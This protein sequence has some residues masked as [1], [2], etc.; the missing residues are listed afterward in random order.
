[1]S[2]LS[3]DR[4]AHSKSEPKL[5][6]IIGYPSSGTTLLRDILDVH[7]DLRIAGEMP[8]LLSLVSVSDLT[9]TR[10]N[11]A[12][13]KDKVLLTDVYEHFRNTK[14][15]YEDLEQRFEKRDGF[16]VRHVYAGLL[17]A[18]YYAYYGNKT[19]QYTESLD[20]LWSLFPMTKVI[21]VVR[22]IRDVVLSF[23][24]KWNKSCLLAA[25]KWTQRM[26]SGV[27]SMES[28]PKDMCLIVR[29]EDLLD[30]PQQQVE[31]ICRFLEV[32]VSDRMLNHTRFRRVHFAG[33]K[34]IN[35]EIDPS[36][37]GK[38]RTQLSLATA[39]RVEEIAFEMMHR[40]GY[41][42]EVAERSKRLWW[43]QR[44][45]LEFRD[46]LAALTFGNKYSQ[47]ETLWDRLEHVSLTLKRRLFVRRS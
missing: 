17:D 43:V 4:G 2:S 5:I 34:N 19:P 6:H 33:K 3:M 13:V 8:L 39:R 27:L 24:K 42:P 23:K 35:S 28:M 7:P 11:F 12:W 16:K 22:D 41:R 44:I 20:E 32:P 38:W 21:C 31:A 10:E 29:Y 37:L 30:H 40:F 36:N 1:M 26:R 45:L 46:G 14:L 47:T 9:I 25:Q 18:G 15:T